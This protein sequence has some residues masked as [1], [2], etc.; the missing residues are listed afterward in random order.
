MF[1]PYSCPHPWGRGRSGEN[2]DRFR[3]VEDEYLKLRGQLAAKRINRQQFEAALQSLVFQDAQGRHWMI[4]MDSGN[5]NLY[6][7]QRWVQ[8]DPYVGAASPGVPPPNVAVPPGGPPPASWGQPPQFNV[9]VA[10]PAASYPAPTQSGGGCCKLLACG[11][12]VI[13]LLV[14][15]VGA[16]GYLAVQSGALNKDKLL[17]L[18]GIGPAD[19]RIDNFRDDAIY[20]TITQLEVAKDSTPE[21]TT[22]A[23]NSF[24]ILAHRF[25]N[26]GR[27]RVDF[28]TARGSANLGACTLTVKPG[29]RYEFVPLP[30]KIVVNRANNPS[31]AGADYVITTSALCR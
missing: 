7:G 23:L 30:S 20:V 28:G 29:D 17:G 12:L 9:Y 21:Q 6:D 14:I 15:G 11:C 13:V 25:Q 4:G 27:F 26:P 2:M 24:D 8:A 18:V 16:C 1:C 31:S 22:L 10:P 19:L 3:Q 5:W